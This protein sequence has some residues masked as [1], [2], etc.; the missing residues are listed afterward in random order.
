[1]TDDRR[2]KLSYTFAKKSIKNGIIDLKEKDKSK[3]MTT[4]NRDTFEV[5]FCNTQRLKKSALPYIQR[6]L[7]ISE[8]LK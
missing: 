4:R 2:E 7:N 8:A 1:M 6:S 5:T 3:Y